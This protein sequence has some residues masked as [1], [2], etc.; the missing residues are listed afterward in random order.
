M[1]EP[2]TAAT[3]ASVQNA[4]GA[5]RLLRS[6]PGP[7]VIFLVALAG[8]IVAITAAKGLADPDYFWHV[9]AGKLIATSGIPSTD[10]FSFTWAGK[11]W[12]PHEWL[13]ELLIYQVVRAFGSGAVLVLFGLIGAA[14]IGVMA[15]VLRRHG[16]RTL[17]VIA[18]CVVAAL[19]LSPYL[20]VRPQVISW[21]MLAALVA[22][23]MSL[24]AR[25]PARALVLIPFFVLW[26]NLHGLWVVGLGV[27]F[28]YAAFTVAGCTPMSES[29]GRRWMLAALGGAILATMLTPAGPA[30]V[31]YPLRYIDAGDWGLANIQEWQSP[32][33]HDPAHLGLL[34]LIVALI[35]NGGRATPGWLVLL[36][37]IGVAAA[38]VSLRNAPIAAVLSMPVLA[39]GIESRL[40]A[41]QAQRDAVRSRPTRERPFS[42]QL[43][44]RLMEGL[45]ALVI[46]MGAIVIRP[47]V[48]EPVGGPYPEAGVSVLEKV[49][50]AARVLAEY[51][52]GGYVIH[53]LYELG[54]RVFVDGRND[55]YDQSILED[56]SAIRAADADWK[57]LADRY[58]VDAML[59]PP[60]VP[61]V[62]G[63]ATANGWCEAFRDAHQVLLLR[64]CA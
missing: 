29:N 8:V 18:A 46:I 1:S 59:F 21:L 30:G 14:T 31:L 3:V 62:K 34:L 5:A 49:Q 6:L 58:E 24:S 4:D 60:G 19:V 15:L 9:T 47:P 20:T 48:I 33:F 10:P 51:G 54:G 56:Y 44:R 57:Q 11:P 13:S 55:M 16:V 25:H 52:W 64:S 40:A 50:P 23:L 7:T 22:I 39:F 28:V 37:W 53:R 36:S 35:W 12:T 32:N 27:V 17:A 41:R 45:V 42:I 26:A 61:I 2:D 38:L 63:I 43:G